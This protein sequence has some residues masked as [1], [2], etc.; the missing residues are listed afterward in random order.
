MMTTIREQVERIN[1]MRSRLQRELFAIQDACPHT[2]KTGKYGANTGNWCASDDD[3]W[4]SVQC[5]DCKHTWTIYNSEN[6]VGYKTFD[7]EIIRD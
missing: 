7:G 3:Y 6:P 5:S 1:T 4:I 2:T